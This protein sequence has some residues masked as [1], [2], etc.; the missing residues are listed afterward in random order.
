VLNAAANAGL[1]PISDMGDP[2]E[3]CVA[4]DE[5]NIVLSM[6]RQGSELAFVRKASLN[7]RTAFRNSDEH[8]LFLDRRGRAYS[9]LGLVPSELFDGALSAFRMD[10]V[11]SLLW[12]WAWV[13]SQVN[14]P[15]QD[16]LE[17]VLRTQNL[18]TYRKIDLLV[19]ES[20]KLSN[21]QRDELARLAQLVNSDIV[22]EQADSSNYRVT[23]LKPGSDWPLREYS[24]P[25]DGEP[26][27]RLGSMVGSVSIG[28]SSKSASQV[29]LPSTG[30]SWLSTGKPSNFQDTKS[31]KKVIANPGDVITPSIGLSSVAR[32]ADQ[33]MALATG[34]FALVPN[35]D[36]DAEAI[37]DFLN[38]KNAQQQRLQAVQSGIIPRLGKKDLLDF[39]FVESPNIRSRLHKF[40]LGMVEQ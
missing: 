9:N 13:N 19:P 6:Q 2:I 29:G 26:K 24:K 30:G 31:A 38:S 1:K 21:R 36:Q 37:S 28:N 39:E 22:S 16:A 34:H 4:L 10:S 7:G 17:K 15:W 40:F 23:K 8:L 3:P 5:E 11:E 35:S 20:P 27:I 18:R 12:A 32:I 25:S 33:E 14:S